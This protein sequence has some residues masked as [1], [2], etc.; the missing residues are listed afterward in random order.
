[1]NQF[2]KLIL[3]TLLPSIIACAVLLPYIY[4]KNKKGKK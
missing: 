4:S 2:A 3:F 1:M